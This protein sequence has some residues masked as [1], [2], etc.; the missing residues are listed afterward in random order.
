MTMLSERVYMSDGYYLPIVAE[1]SRYVNESTDPPLIPPARAR[2]AM[3]EGV[4]SPAALARGLEGGGT[5]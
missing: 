3:C 5:A 4:A 2:Q 1:M